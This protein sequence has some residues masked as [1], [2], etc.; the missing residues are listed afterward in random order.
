MPIAG[1]IPIEFGKLTIPHI[2]CAPA[3][4]H[5]GYGSIRVKVQER[6]QEKS[7]DSKDERFRP[8]WIFHLRGKKRG[9]A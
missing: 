3:K 5:G 6:L 2:P 4:S 8:I 9:K 1:Q 7:T